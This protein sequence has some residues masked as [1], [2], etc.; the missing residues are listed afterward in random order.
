M[1]R[2]LIIPANLTQFEGDGGAMGDSGQAG[3]QPATEGASNDNGQTA[4]VQGVQASQSPEDLRKE[5][6]ELIK[7][8][9]KDIHTQEFKKHLNRRLGDQKKLT[10]ELE[11]H[12][13]LI[14][15]VSLKYG[16]SDIG[17]LMKL[18]ESD[19]HLLEQRAFDKGIPIET[20]IEMEKQEMNLRKIKAEAEREKGLRMEMERQQSEREQYGKWLRD[21]EQIK[22]TNPDFDLNTEVEN[23]QFVALLQSGIDMQHAYNVIHMN[24]IVNN[25]AKNAMLKSASA[26]SSTIAARGQRP[27]ENAGS[28]N[29]SVA[30]K[31]DVHSFTAK[32]REDIARRVARGEKISF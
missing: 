5:Y 21:A 24:E 30:F 16:E 3:T 23:P 12:R 27:S 1:L 25:T 17:E 9:F 2:R 22:Q 13:G 4:D 14:D 29:S 8:K 7:G 19:N 11:S 10:D 31:R 32:D 28:S 18:V 6:Q 20:L 15:L 26:V